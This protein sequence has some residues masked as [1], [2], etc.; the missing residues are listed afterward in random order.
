MGWVTLGE[1]LAVPAAPLTITASRTAG[2]AWRE[3][4]RLWDVLYGVAL[5]LETRMSRA[6]LLL[7]AS[8][9]V[10][11]LSISA[12]PAAR[13][14]DAAQPDDAASS[15]ST[16]PRLRSVERPFLLMWKDG[17]D[18]IALGETKTALAAAA[19]R[20]AVDYLNYWSAPNVLTLDA[21]PHFFASKVLFHGRPMSA[22]ALAR[23]KRRFTQR[24]PHRNYVPR[25]GT[26]RTTCKASGNACTVRTAFDFTAASPTRGSQS[27]G[28]AILEL[29]MNFVGGR[30]VIVSESSRVIRRQ[31]VRRMAERADAT[32]RD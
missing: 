8:A 6:S 29:G 5:R 24:W 13:A 9:A 17:R 32:V 28:R 1:N 31:S 26:M 20:L 21:T 23:E 30:P 22:R 2:H 18:Q 3:Q 11:L 12:L 7:R 27:E 19:Q 25:L 14:Q 10:V 15:P 4:N 16:S